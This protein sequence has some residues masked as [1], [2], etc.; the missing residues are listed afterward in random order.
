MSTMPNFEANVGSRKPES[1]HGCITVDKLMFH[2]G[3]HGGSSTKPSSE[4]T[5]RTIVWKNAT[6]MPA[7]IAQLTA[8]VIRLEGRV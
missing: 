5:V 3:F 4:A 2:D 7:M 8:G 1:L 6:Q